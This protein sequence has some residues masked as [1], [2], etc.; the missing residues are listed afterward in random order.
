MGV[1]GRVA[2]D[3]SLRPWHDP[4]VLA[5]VRH[6]QGTP[7]ATRTVGCGRVAGRAGSS[8]SSFTRNG[9]KQGVSQPKEGRANV[10]SRQAT[11]TKKKRR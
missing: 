11:L 6:E 2:F 4:S 8:A 10:R 3:R 1:D 9:L 7:R 5:R